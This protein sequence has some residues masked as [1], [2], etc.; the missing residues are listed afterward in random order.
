[1]LAKIYTGKVRK[2]TIFLPCVFIMPIY[3]K[4]ADD[5]KIASKI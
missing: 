3:I 2:N 5:E 4:N 1:M